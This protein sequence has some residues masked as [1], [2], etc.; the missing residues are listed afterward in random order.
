MELRFWIDPETDLPHIYNHGVTEEEVEW[1]L[2]DPDVE[3]HGTDE[4]IV[5]IGRTA[6]RRLLKV[7]Y[8][9][10]DDGVGAFVIT[11]YRLKGKALIAHNRYMRSRR[12]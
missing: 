9:P 6:S 5:A 11:A 12:K 1:V 10:D 2:A 3:S 4:S 8:A 7:I